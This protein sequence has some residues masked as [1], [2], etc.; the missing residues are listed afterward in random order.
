MTKLDFE[1]LNY[2]QTIQK[3]LDY[4]TIVENLAIDLITQCRFSDAMK[5]LT[6][7]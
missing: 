1:L 6:L 2:I 3:E 5:V 4:R 7:I